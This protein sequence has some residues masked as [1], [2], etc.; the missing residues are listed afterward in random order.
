MATNVV[1]GLRAGERLLGSTSY[2]SEVGEKLSCCSFN[3]GFIFVPTTSSNVPKKSR[4]YS[5]SLVNK[6]DTHPPRAVKEHVDATVD[7]LGTDHWAQRFDYLDE[8]VSEHEFPVDALLLV[9]KSLLEKQWTLSTEETTT[10]ENNS[11]KVVKGC[12]LE[13]VD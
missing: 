7:S 11:K 5:H 2:Y 12:L 13:S 1:V 3:L 6:R 9:H 8:E 4:N 10:I